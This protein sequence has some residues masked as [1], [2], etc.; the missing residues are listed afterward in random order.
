VPLKTVAVE[1]DLASA[2]QLMVEG[3]L[4]QVPVMQAGRAVGLLRRADMLRFL[5]LRDELHLAGRGG[6]SMARRAA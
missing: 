1:A 5:Q 6:R 2:L 3:S 4:N